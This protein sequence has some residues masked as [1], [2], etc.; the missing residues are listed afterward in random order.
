MGAE[1]GISH[2]KIGGIS[3]NYDNSHFFS[4]HPPEEMTAAGVDAWV[5]QFVGTEVDELLFCPNS[6]RSSVASNARQTVWDGYDPKGGSSQPFLAGIPENKRWP[7]FPTERQHFWNWVHGAWLLHS[8]G[9]DPYARWMVRCHKHRISPWLSMRMNDVHYVENPKHSIHDQFWKEHPEFRRDP[10]G[11]SYNGQCLDYGQPE[12]R[13][14]QM[15]YIREL[16]SRYD[17]DGFELDWLRNPY[18]FRPGREKEGLA[19]LT[20]FTA[21]VRQLL[22]VRSKELGHPVQLGVRVPD[23]PEAARALGFD[24]HVWVER[25]LI[26]RLVVSPFLFT[27][28]DMP[29]E[30]WKKALGDSPTVLEAGLMITIRPAFG[31]GYSTGGKRAEGL[32]ISHNLETVRGAAASLLDRGADRI[33]LFNFF[34]YMPYGNTGDKYRQSVAGRAFQQTLREIG[35]LRTMK[36]KSR[37]HLVT[38]ADIVVPGIPEKI[39]L[40]QELASGAAG[41]FRISTG[42][43]PVD[44]QLVQ[45]RFAIE[46]PEPAKGAEWEVRINGTKCRSLG[47]MTPPPASSAPTHAFEAPVSAVRRGLNE[48]EIQN[49][50]DVK[51]QLMWVEM[52]FS[53]PEG[54][55][56]DGGVEVEQLDPEFN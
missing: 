19:I 37:R 31:G 52:A 26:D 47:R 7:G 49:L 15:A 51:L 46:Q 18:H 56:S 3:L 40:P 30:R 13:A 22:D 14:Y 34:D 16:V 25:K 44:G 50:S 1:R 5:D 27:Q 6:Q 36:G 23:L 24:V 9:I 45:V 53:G 35:S 54:K 33:Y 43:V 12:V 55:W 28:F 38:N 2:R 32:T 11:D 39:L 41:V 17:M 8:R 21:E 42:P 48:V 4:W 10:Q 29:M 20:E